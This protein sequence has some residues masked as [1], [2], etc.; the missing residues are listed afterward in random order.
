MSAENLKMNSAKWQKDRDL[1]AKMSD[2]EID[3]SDF[4]P[5][6]DEFF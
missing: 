1:L 2:D 6:D 3:Y 5:L 4:P